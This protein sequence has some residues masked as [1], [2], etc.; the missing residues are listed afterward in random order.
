MTRSASTA[1]LNIRVSAAERMQLEAAAR[2]ARTSLSDFVRRKAVEGA[3]A[4]LLKRSVVVIPA[5]E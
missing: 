1:V 2:Y 4:E 3:E 5:T